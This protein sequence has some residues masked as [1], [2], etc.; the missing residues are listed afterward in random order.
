M[1]YEKPYPLDVAIGKVPCM[2]DIHYAI[3]NITI[4]A[5]TNI[6]SLALYDGLNGDVRNTSIFSFEEAMELLINR[7][8]YL[9]DAIVI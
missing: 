1:K 7:K 2:D 6:I 4:F 3:W 8:L 9:S 5:T